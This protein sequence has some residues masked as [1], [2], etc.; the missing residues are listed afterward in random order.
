M[1]DRNH[2]DKRSNNNNAI[3]L[4]LALLF[5]L[6]GL[7]MLAK[8]WGFDLKKFLGLTPGFGMN[9]GAGTSQT[10]AAGSR[11]ATGTSGTGTGSGGSGSGSGTGGGT[12]TTSLKGTKVL[13][14]TDTGAVIEAGIDKD[15]QVFVDPNVNPNASGGTGAGVDV[16]DKPVVN[17]KTLLP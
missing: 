13:L 8:A 10:G 3:L 9:S 7:G 11:G 1:K 4:V 17:T 5:F 15:G 2:T 12:G 16:N 14:K 6:F